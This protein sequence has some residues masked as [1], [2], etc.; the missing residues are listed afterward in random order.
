VTFVPTTVATTAA[1]AAA[2]RHLQMLR[3]EEEVMTRYSADETEGWE[4]KIVRSAT[5]K[6]KRPEVVR[7]LVEEEARAG[8]ELLEKF[9]DSRI[10]FKRRV[11]Q[12][13]DDVHRDLDP[14][15]TAYGWTSDRL[16]LTL[17]GVILGLVALV[18][19]LVFLFSS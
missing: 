6:F 10:R 8:W 3:T 18:G 12:R 7:Q 14:Y 17:A 1:T 11:E 16:G 2:A 9:D 19:L 4:F 5:A 13:A 15:R